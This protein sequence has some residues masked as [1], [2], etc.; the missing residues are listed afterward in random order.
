[1]GSL[2]AAPPMVSAVIATWNVAEHLAGCLDSLAKS[3]GSMNI[4]TIIIGNS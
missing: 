4:E 3:G 2:N 1:M